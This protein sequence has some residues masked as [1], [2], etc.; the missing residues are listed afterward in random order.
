MVEGE[1]ILGS[2]IYCLVLSTPELQQSACPTHRAWPQL[3]EPGVGSRPIWK[4]GPHPH[5]EF[6]GQDSHIKSESPVLRVLSNASSVLG[7]NSSKVR[8]VSPQ[9]FLVGWVRLAWLTKIAM[10]VTCTEQTPLKLKT[11]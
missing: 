11:I 1:A 8:V 7:D 2:A 3:P 5:K 9:V 6:I 10:P 4:A